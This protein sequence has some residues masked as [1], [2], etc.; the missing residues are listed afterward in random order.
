MAVGKQ[1]QD[2]AIRIGC[3]AMMHSLVEPT[4][5]RQQPEQQNRYSRNADQ[6][7]HGGSETVE[8]RA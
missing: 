6:D 4:V 2:A 8:C 3:P 1:A 7:P 5:R